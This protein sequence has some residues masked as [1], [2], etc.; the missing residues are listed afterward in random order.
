MGSPAQCG[1]HKPFTTSNHKSDNM[2]VLI[3]FLLSVSIPLSSSLF[4]GPSRSSCRTDRDCPRLAS[5]GG[6][7]QDQVNWLCGLGN[8][9]RRNKENCFFRSCAQCV[10]DVDCGGYRYC[11]NFSCRQRT[12]T[13]RRYNR[14]RG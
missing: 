10:N 13:N 8:A 2:K 1:A 11:N 5:S 9:F 6:R 4:F 3:V 12:R 7:C 14:Y